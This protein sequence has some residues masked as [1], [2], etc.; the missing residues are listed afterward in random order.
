MLG[1]TPGVEYH[2]LNSKRFS[3]YVG[4]IAGYENKTSKGVYEDVQQIFTGGTLTYK[5]AKTETK[6]AWNGTSA[7]GT[8]NERGYSKL[9]FNA[10]LGADF[11]IMKHLYMGLELGVGYNILVYKE[12]EV[13]IDGSLD[14]KIPKAKENDFG[15]NVNNAIRLGFWF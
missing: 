12:I 9:S 15:V 2:F 11:Y 4:V 8:Y 14:T 5:M 7:L 6:N 13:S 1:V 10:V 3:P